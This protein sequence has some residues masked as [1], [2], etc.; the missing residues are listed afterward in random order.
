[1]SKFIKAFIFGYPIKHSLSPHIHHYWL[2]HFNIIGSYEKFEI[3]PEELSDA[4]IDM[5]KKGYQG[6]NITLPHKQAIFDLCDEVDEA[7]QKIGAIN[8]ISFKEKK[9]VGLNRDWFGFCESLHQ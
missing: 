7:A 2:N 9:I 6:G 3:K 4:L 1:M 8:T 5:R